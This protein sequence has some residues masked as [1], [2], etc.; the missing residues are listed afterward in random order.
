MAE[1]ASII[2]EEVTINGSVTGDEDLVLAGRVD[3]Q[4]SL[5]KHLSVEETGAVLQGVD[6][7]DLT[8]RGRVEGEVKVSRSLIIA[9]SGTVVG[10]ITTPSLVM[11]EGARFSGSVKMIVA[12]PD[13][14]IE[15]EP[16][17]AR[18]FE[19]EWDALSSDLGKAEA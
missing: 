6:V 16:P 2:L 9:A 15:P 5:S 10:N 14:L 17:A 19:D 4:I 12:L 3:G 18:T 1:E 11:E 7:E 8:V 13:E